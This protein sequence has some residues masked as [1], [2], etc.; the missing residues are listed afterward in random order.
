MGTSCSGMAG[1]KIAAQDELPFQH[2]LSSPLVFRDLE[3]LRKSGV[4]DFLEDRLWRSFEK[5]DDKDSLRLILMNRSA[6]TY[7]VKF[8]LS[9]WEESGLCSLS[10]MTD[11]SG[12][13]LSIAI[14]NTVIIF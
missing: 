8:I 10:D 2:E 4:A 11:W 14:V 1:R 12:E 6:K 13:T 9:Q 3:S 5:S 7:F